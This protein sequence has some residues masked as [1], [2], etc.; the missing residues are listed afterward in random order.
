[1]F[2]LTF[3]VY[4]GMSIY[5]VIKRIKNKI[6]FIQPFF[7]PF[8]ICNSVFSTDIV[9][10][11][12]FAIMLFTYFIFNIREYGSSRKLVQVA[13]MVPGLLSFLPFFITDHDMST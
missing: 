1:M 13:F 8:I 11:V 7:I 4:F 6:L 12:L 5:R 10:L 3:I 2:L 9:S